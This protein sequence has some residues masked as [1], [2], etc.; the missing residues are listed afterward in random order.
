MNNKITNN[1]YN[2]LVKIIDVD[3]L[4]EKGHLKYKSEGFMD[5]NIDYLNGN[6]HIHNIAMAHNYICNGDVI[7]DPD[8]EIRIDTEK[9]IVDVICYQD[10]FTFKRVENDKNKKELN[11]FLNTWLKNIL[12]QEYKLIEKDK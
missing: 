5:L 12:N 6:N 10:G 7:P 3:T 8:V 1:N 4:K 11:N 9:E 2:K